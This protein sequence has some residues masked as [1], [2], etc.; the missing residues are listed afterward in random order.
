MQT[1]PLLRVD[2]LTKVYGGSRSAGIARGV[3]ALNDVSLSIAHGA[4]L[5]LVGGSG[6]GKSTLA[7]C[8]AC[9]E[10]PSSGRVL[11]EGLELTALPEDELRRVRR[12]IQLVFQDPGASLNPRFTAGQI[13]GE[14]LSIEGLTRVERTR[15]VEDLMGRV[16]LSASLLS[17]RAGA[18]SGGQKQR[19][20]IARALALA[21]KV[22][23]LDEALSALDCSVQA[24]IVNLLADLQASTGVAY[25]FITHDLAMAAHIADEIAVMDKG[26]VVERGPAAGLVANPRHAATTALVA[27]MRHLPAP[28]PGSAPGP[29]AGPVP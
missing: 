28:R 25:L 8:A 1:Q 18:L 19:L 26:A 9:L 11:F 20:A 27:A 16:G 3:T 7:L 14:P 2:G 22:I 10:R 6:S 4:T 21:P 13:V 24:Q 15:Q 23:I 5:A 29:A 17:R 12:K